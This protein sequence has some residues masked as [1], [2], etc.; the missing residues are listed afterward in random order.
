M[1][2]R[3]IFNFNDGFCDKV[4]IKS[5]DRFLRSNNVSIC[6]AF[7]KCS[8]QP[9][10]VY[11]AGPMEF[12]ESLGIS[13]RKYASSI[14]NDAHIITLSPQ[15]FETELIEE[16]GGLNQLNRIKTAKDLTEFNTLMRRIAELDLYLIAH[17]DI[18]LVY[19]EGE[20]FSGTVDEVC[21][22]Y[23]WEKQVVLASSLEQKDIPGWF[24]AHCTKVYTGKYSLDTAI[25]YILQQRK[26]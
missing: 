20:K 4:E 16:Y 7:A 25:N 12:A 26:E 21:N 8:E 11:L 3:S 10:V 17:S 23:R 22:A 19:Y 24:M 18:V 6:G 5:A 13:W 2:I 15:D 1:N 14:L 9:N